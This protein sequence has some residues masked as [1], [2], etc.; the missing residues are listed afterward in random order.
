[1]T[2]FATY[3]PIVNF[4]YFVMTIGFTMFF[5]NPVCL[6]ISFFCSFVFS[7]LLG[8]RKTLKT[9]LLY[10]LPMMLVM[11]V[12]NPFFN[13][14]GVTVIRYMRNG[15]PLTAESIVY[16]F[17]ASLM[18]ISVISWFSSYNKVMTSDKF[19]YLFGRI[20]P[21]LSLI[22]SMTLR[23]VPRFAAQMKNVSDAR[24]CMGR[25]PSSGGIFKR[26]RFGLDTLS[27]VV[28]W[29]LENAVETS[30]SMRARGYGL[31]GRSAFSIFRFNS[32]DAKALTFI[33]VFGVYTLVCGIMGGLY[34]R[35]F[36]SVKW[37]EPSVFGIFGYVSYFLLCIFP[38][39]IEFWEVRRWRAL[40]S[41]T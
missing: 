37:A 2:G 15:N 20:I 11:S 31:A 18:I 38:V 36:P 24:R 39:I 4:I 12:M 35:Y 21:S 6:L 26:I 27:V 13:H 5:M 28:T 9:N 8:G 25:D 7:V 41:K 40:R 16:G 14:E 17:F 29:S 34:F 33:C 3:H 30:D 10:M 22:I 32:R 19:I 1:M 23:F